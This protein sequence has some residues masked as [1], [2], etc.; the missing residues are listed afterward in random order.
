MQYLK[1]EV[2]YAFNPCMYPGCRK[3]ALSS[4]DSSGNLSEAPG[5]CLEHQKD[6]EEILYKMRN[7]ILS[8]EKIVGLNASGITVSDLDLSGKKF[9]GCNL[10]HCKHTCHKHEG[11]N[12]YVRFFN[13]D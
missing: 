13:H 8:H 6:A 5:F 11:E 3:Q 9:Y 4:F 12:V 7:Y 2:M 10:Q 1:V